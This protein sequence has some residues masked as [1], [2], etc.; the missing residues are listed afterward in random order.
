MVDVGRNAGDDAVQFRRGAL[1]ERRQPQQGLL[2]DLQLVDIL[3]VDL[4]FDLQI[5]GLRDDHHD[6]VAGGDHAAHGMHGGLQ[7][8]AVLRG[9]DVGP[10]Q[11]VF[12]GDLALDEF[13]DL[14]VGLAQILGHVA[15]H[16]LIDLDDLQFGF[17]DLALG[18]GARSNVLR[19]L[20]G[21]SCGVALERGQ[22]RHLH[23]MLVVE[24]AN[25]DQFLLHQRDLLVFGFLLRGKAG[26]LLV[27]LGNALA[28]LRLL[29]DPAIDA[30]VEQLGLARHD[31]PD[32]GVIGAIE[33]HPGKLDLVE[34]ALLGLQS[35][36]PRPQAIEV[37]GDDRQT[38][39]GDGV[40][41]PHHH[42]AGLDEIT[43]S[44]E[45]FADNA[46]GRVLHLLHVGFDDDRSR[47]N[48]RAR[49]LRRRCP[50]AD[51]AGQN[52]N[53]GQP[54]DQMQPDRSARAL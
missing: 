50:A 30:N 47:R 40:V 3:R 25:S 20:A 27:K 2:A 11:L 15:D 37:L 32:I 4:G 18:L 23:Q 43:V 35:C 28:Q 7:H 52:D 38:R 24:I 45:H 51:P 10:P 42:V 44:R 13:A 31:V 21:Q 46:A 49:D 34:P 29:P 48:Q 26:D 33:Q 39:L 1:V 8:H 36:G 53:H 54:D 6:G 16:V 41:E 19:P 22:P 5:V 9:A 17:G 12:G 14:V